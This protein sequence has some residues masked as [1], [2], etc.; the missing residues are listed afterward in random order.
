[1]ADNDISEE[2]RNLFRQTMKS[3]KP[4][5]HN[6]QEDNPPIKP[7]RGNKKTVQPITPI[8]L[9]SFYSEEVQAHST[10]SYACHGIPNKRFRQLKSGLIPWQ[11]RLDLHGLSVE[12]AEIKLLDFITQHY[13]SGNRCILLIH[14]KGGHRN[15]APILKNLVNHWLK[16]IPLVL[17]FHSAIAKD[18]GTGALYVLLKRNRNQ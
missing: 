10:L 16:Q 17:A 7:S 12:E 6:K 14:G 3:V 2:N 8:A 4:L 5:A 15:Q 9:S 13:D 11:G 1:M 18:G